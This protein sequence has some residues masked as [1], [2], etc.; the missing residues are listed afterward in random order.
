MRTRGQSNGEPKNCYRSCPRSGRSQVFVAFANST[1]SVDALTRRLKRTFRSRIVHSLP[2]LGAHCT[3]GITRATSAFT[4][5]V[6]DTTAIERTD[7]SRRGVSLL[8]A[9]LRGTAT[10]FLGV[11]THCLFRGAFCA[12]EVG[13]FIA[14][15]QLSMVVRTTRGRTCRSTLDSCRP[16]F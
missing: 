7:D 8:G 11:R 12:R 13:N 16:L 9:G 6:V 15:R 5:A 14:T 2:S 3:V 10:V 1:D 4:R